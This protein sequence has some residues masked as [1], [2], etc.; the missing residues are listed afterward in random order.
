MCVRVHVSV[1]VADIYVLIK[2]N[3]YVIF[4]FFF[5]RSSIGG[6]LAYVTDFNSPT[7]WAATFRLRGYIGYKSVRVVLLLLVVLL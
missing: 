3:I 4:L 5:L 6:V 2:H 7:T 1:C